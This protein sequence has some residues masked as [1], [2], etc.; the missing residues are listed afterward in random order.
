M[1]LN[2]ILSHLP[3]ALSRCLRRADASVTAPRPSA[4][5]P[6]RAGAALLPT[7]VLVLGAGLVAW[8]AAPAGLRGQETGDLPSPDS[9]VEIED[10][11]V[12][13]NR[14][15][16][17]RDELTVS[18]TVIGR[19]EIR[20]SGA[21]SVAELLRDVPGVQV[22]RTG[23][24][25]GTASL[26]VRGGESNYVRVLVDGVPVNRPGGDFDFSTLSTTN[27]ERIE[28]V[29]GP[30]SVV[31][32]SDA[33]T[34]VVQV[35]TRDGSGPPEATVSAAGGSH[36]T[37]D[38][39]ASV[40]GGD[41]RLSYSLALS[42]F[43]TDGL[44]A[45][46]NHFRHTVGS[47]RVRLR[48][49]ERTEA[50]VVLRYG[51][52]EAHTPTD[53]AGR[54]VDENQYG[55]GE[56]LV[57]GARLGRELTDRLSGRVELRLNEVDAGFDDAPDGPA[58]TLGIYA[59]RS[60]SDLSRRSVDARLDFRAE[61]GTVLTAGI[62]REEQEERSSNE[63]L[64]G[65]GSSTG[66][67]HASRGNTGLYLQAL[68]RPT[69]RLDL[70]AGFRLD[71][72]EAFG[73]FDTWRV[74][75]AYRLPSRTRLRASFGTAFKAPTFLENYSTG[76]VR[77]N[78]E[79][80]P[81]TSTSWEAGVEQTLPSLGLSLG[82]TWFDQSFE[83][84]VQYTGS[85]P[86]PDAPNY[87]NVAAAAARGLEATAEL[88]LAAET[89]V[90]ASYSWLDTEVEDAGFQT[91]P[92]AA[93]VE[94]DRLLRRPA[95]TARLGLHGPLPRDGTASLDLR[96]VGE[97]EDRDFSSFPARRVVLDDYLRMDLG[98]RLPLVRSRGGSPGLVGTLRVQNLWDAAYQEVRGFPAP[99]RTVVAGIEVS[100][101]L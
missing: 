53:G 72:N 62:E 18:A 96:W 57:V 59:F 79:L 22:T 75:A 74:G 42:R 66:A 15:P 68:S 24:W 31:Y 14:L 98:A 23:S 47:A 90:E 73:T 56:D 26:F 9:V 101:G 87:F 33:V 11:V 54:A 35:F 91:G 39:D 81:E 83:Q 36:G 49:D 51:D 64:S 41:E 1:I 5:G 78:P 45:F 27:V 7:A 95:H 46:N 19:E 60:E 93:F 80:E 71:D 88:E 67:M 17:P 10:L 25:G 8:A 85:P 97:R 100:A 89:G 6:G 43:A 44:R 20:R 3:S 86:A 84:L 12:T 38:W 94:G 50:A 29:R 69:E 61:G 77:G 16:V 55:F 76:Y 48:P 32:G 34:G 37:L 58:D 92:D 52:H 30:S 28:V 21:E 65:F 4:A 63:S 13:A 2:H 82:L 40:A 70:S 99:G